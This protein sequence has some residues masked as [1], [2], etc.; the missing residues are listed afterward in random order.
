MPLTI[1]LYVWLRLR[2]E[3]VTS[4]LLPPLNLKGGIVVF[5]KHCP[6]SCLA[7]SLTAAAAPAAHARGCLKP[8]EAEIFF[9]FRPEGGRILDKCPAACVWLIREERT[10]VPPSF[11][12]GGYTRCFLS[13]LS[14]FFFL[15]LCEGSTP[16]GIC[17]VPL[18]II[19]SS[20]FRGCPGFVLR[21]NAR[22][23]QARRQREGFGVVVLTKELRNCPESGQCSPGFVSFRTF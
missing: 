16:R 10:G 4:P 7:A 2:F 14:R 13:G 17:Q 21:E 22:G 5:C 1:C 8:T 19:S 20:V 18:K 12:F 23:R 15:P 9:S 3:P 6:A 11:E